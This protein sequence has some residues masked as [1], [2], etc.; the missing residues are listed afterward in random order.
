MIA[1]V[2]GDFDHVG[3][4]VR[5]L[6]EAATWAREALGLELARTATLPQYGIDAYFL[7]PGS[8]TLEI[9]TLADAGLLDARLEG[10]PRRLDHVAFRVQG[11]DALTAMLR[12]SGARFCTPDRAQ[13]IAEPLEVGPMRQIWTVPAS[14]GGLALQLNEPLAH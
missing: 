14:T 9:F 4:V 12:A 6:D 1:A 13:E 11:I 7:G 5:D 8:G 10:Q 3:W 2:F